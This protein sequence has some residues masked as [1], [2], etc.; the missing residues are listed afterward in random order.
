MKTQTN[1]EMQ[2][3][4]LKPAH[5]ILSS[6]ILLALALNLAACNGGG[7]EQNNAVSPASADFDSEVYNHKLWSDLSPEQQSKN[8]PTGLLKINI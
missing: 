6:T 5:Q 7:G 1:N 4:T 2:K 8:E 3:L